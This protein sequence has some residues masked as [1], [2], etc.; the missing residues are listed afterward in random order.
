MS[1][2]WII[3]VVDWCNRTKTKLVIIWIRLWALTPGWNGQN[4]SRIKAWTRET[5]SLW[6]LAGRSVHSV[7]SK[8]GYAFRARIGKRNR[9]NYLWSISCL[10]LRRT[11][12][13]KAAGCSSHGDSWIILVSFPSNVTLMLLEVFLNLINKNFSSVTIALSTNVIREP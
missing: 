2:L 11:G 7:V 9:K 1:N 12:D 4:A 10:R 8:T 6:I 3:S 5:L 13:R